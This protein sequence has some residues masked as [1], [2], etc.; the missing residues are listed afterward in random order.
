MMRKCGGYVV[1]STT[2]E[3]VRTFVPYPL[4]LAMDGEANDLLQKANQNLARHSLAGD[5]VPSLDRFIYAFVRKEAV[6]SSQIASG[7]SATIM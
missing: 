7:S 3:E 4:P 5:M 1:P 2:G 6:L